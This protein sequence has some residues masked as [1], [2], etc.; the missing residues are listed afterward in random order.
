MYRHILIPTD[1]SRLSLKAALRKVKEAA[2]A[3]KVACEAILKTA[4]DRKCDVIVMGSHGR[5]LILAHSMTR[6]LVCR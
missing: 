3:E 4:R 5:G 2:A 6:V 1:G